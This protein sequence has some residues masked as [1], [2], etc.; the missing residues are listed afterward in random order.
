MDRSIPLQSVFK[1][2]APYLLALVAATILL[3][4]FPQIATYLPSAVH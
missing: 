3:M 2:A 1:G 4:L